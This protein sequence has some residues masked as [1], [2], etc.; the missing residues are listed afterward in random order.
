MPRVY[1]ASTGNDEI[2]IATIV[3]VETDEQGNQTLT[4]MVESTEE[5]E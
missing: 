1:I 2:E 5:S 4:L 3:D